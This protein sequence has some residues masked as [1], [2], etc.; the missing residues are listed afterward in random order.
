MTL[1]SLYTTTALVGALTGVLPVTVASSAPA[2]DSAQ[3]PG[4]APAASTR[5]G[6]PAGAL[7]VG[8]DGTGLHWLMRP[9]QHVLVVD[10]VDR[11]GWSWPVRGAGR[12]WT[13]PHVRYS[14]VPSCRAGM[15]CVVVREG[16]YGPTDWSGLTTATPGQ[17]QTFAGPVRIQLNDTY[18]MGAAEHRAVTCHE[19]GHALGLDHDRRASSC[20][21]SIPHALH[22]DAADRGRLEAR[23][24]IGG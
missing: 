10:V 17:M 5:T 3:T 14:Y 18:P 4:P 6:V 1:R 23:Y 16:A 15:P 22:P 12:D 2:R 24:R 11:T 7:A 8:P 9:G 19:L 13:T 21:Q 20:L